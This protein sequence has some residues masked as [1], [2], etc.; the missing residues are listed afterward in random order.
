M[1]KVLLLSIGFILSFFPAFNQ[2]QLTQYFLDGTLYNPAFAG[3]QQAICASIY[4]RQQW[5]GLTDM[6]GNKISPLSGVFSINAPIPVISSGVGLNVVFDKTGFEQTIGVKLNYAYRIPFKDEE[7]SLGIGLGLSLSRKSIDFGQLILQQP[8]D[9]LLQTQQKERAIIP[10]VDFGIQYQQLDKIYVGISGLN[11]LQYSADIGTVGY[12]SKRNIYL[13]AAY[14]LKLMNTQNELYLI[15]SILVKSNLI[16][17]QFDISAR[18]EYNNLFWAGISWRYQDA[19]AVFGGLNLKG[20]RIGA[21]YDLTTSYLSK[22]S[23]GSL[24]VFLGYC[25]T[26]RLKGPHDSCSPWE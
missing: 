18:V 3:S 4:G 22:V 6:N 12:R 9:P 11:L 5:L 23:Y 14:Y 16:N 19:V 25:F 20:F 7:K 21:S 8:G 10:D 26:I 17:V 13:T 15:P 2:V 1:K 24:E